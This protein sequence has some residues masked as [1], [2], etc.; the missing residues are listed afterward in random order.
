MVFGRGSRE[1]H[2]HGSF[3]FLREEAWGGGSVKN[4]R[5]SS[6]VEVTTQS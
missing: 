1:G 6:H 2:R 5:L 3:R 4:A